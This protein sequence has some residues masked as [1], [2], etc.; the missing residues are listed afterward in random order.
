VFF[1]SLQVQLSGAFRFYRAKQ[2]CPLHLYGA[3]KL[4]RCDFKLAPLALQFCFDVSATREDSPNL[5]SIVPATQQLHPAA[6]F[7]VAVVEFQR[8]HRLHSARLYLFCVSCDI[9]LKIIM[10][11]F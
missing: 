11:S 10:T 3:Q 7:A 1:A 6:A 4:A 5:H 8:G 2:V 9:S